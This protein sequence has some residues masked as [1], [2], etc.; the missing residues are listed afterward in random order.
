MRAVTEPDLDGALQPLCAAVQHNCDIADA[1]HAGDYT[2]CVYLL[3]MREYYRWEKGLRFADDLPHDAVGEWLRAREEHWER[4]ADA[5]FQP[6]P[7]DGQRFDPFAAEEL[8][9]ILNPLGLV[10]SGGIGANGRPHFYLA[11]LEALHR[12]D[13]HHIYVSAQEYARDLTAPPAMSQ[14]RTIF[15]RRESV[16][17]MLWEKIEEWRWNRADSAM[18]RAVASYPFAEDL[19]AALDRM[20]EDQTRTML[21]HELGEVA[22]HRILG[23]DWERML[24]EFPRSRA[25][26]LLRAARDNLADC[27]VT[28]PELAQSD[29]LDARIHFYIG[30]LS[31]MRRQLFPAL[32]AAYED[33][34]ATG[35]PRQLQALLPAAQEHWRGLT[36]EALALY[37]RD[38]LEA[39][40]AITRLIDNRPF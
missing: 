24:T 8:N 30:T 23:P 11:R 32:V 28:L 19:E 35:R 22:A 33:W 20:A 17:R 4:L 6:L 21:L 13:D 2:L 34:R 14:G 7:L 36:L 31:N 40:D 9:A 15:L 16:R 3:K 38:G 5:R 1:A 25:E 18:G 37:R 10:Y 39:M 29:T 27:L 12:E 26:I